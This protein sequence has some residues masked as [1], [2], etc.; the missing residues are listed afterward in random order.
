MHFSQQNSIEN[1][2]RIKQLQKKREAI[3]KQTEM[4][5]K[6]IEQYSDL[7]YE[8]I[9]KE[10]EILIQDKY[11][12]EQRAA[13]LQEVQNALK[14]SVMKQ[15]GKIQVSAEALCKHK[16]NIYEHMVRHKSKEAD[17]FLL[18]T[19][20]K[21]KDYFQVLEDNLNQGPLVQEKEKEME[22]LKL[23]NEILKNELEI[24]KNQQQYIREFSN[25]PHIDQDIIKN[26]VNENQFNR[27]NT[28]KH[29]KSNSQLSMETK[30][31]MDFYNEKQQAFSM[32]KE[33]LQ[34]G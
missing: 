17:L 32:N 33:Q 25:N 13:K 19:N 22:A 16:Q 11:N 3:Q 2:N 15:V 20:T 7:D 4:R 8:K 31:I 12:V 29:E 23:Q 26:M 24:H 28:S 5:R 1:D 34:F 18:V 30:Q 21:P 10:N 9:Q 27:I 6:E 14:L